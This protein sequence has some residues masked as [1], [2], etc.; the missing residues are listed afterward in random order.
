MASTTALERDLER[1][2]G[3]E[4]L[5]EDQREYLHDSTE[6]QGL[7]G[8]ADAVVAPGSV[9][10]VRELVAWCYQAGVAM[11]PRGGGTGFAGG[12]VPQGGIVV[13]FE[14]LDRV[15]SFQPEFWRVHLDSGVPTGKVHKLARESGLYFPPD[16]GASE[17]SQIGG[18]VACNAGGPH[19][20]KYGVTGDWVTGLEAVMAGGEL[21]R[22]GG[23]VRK[24]VAAY[25]LR[26]LL[27]GSEGTLGL[28]TGVWL[29]LIP[30]P[31]VQ[32]PLVAAYPGT[33]EGVA[34]LRRVYGYGLR[35][36]VL[37]YLDAGALEAS[38][39]AFPGGLD[40]R[41]RFLVLAEA[42]GS[43]AESAALAQELEEALAEAALSIR[44]VP[45]PAGQRDLWRWRGGVSYAVRNQR[46]GKMSEDIA[47]PFDRLEEALALGEEAGRAVGLPTSSWGHAGDGNLHATFMIDATDPDQIARAA[48]AAEILFEGAVELGGT[49]SG[50]HGL[51]LVKRGQLARQL[52]PAQLELQLELKR[53]FDPKNLFN[54][55]KKVVLR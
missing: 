18:N 17:Q 35:S 36:A 52:N 20:F 27:I 15:R 46:G 49:V 45:T 28:I 3:R 30:A 51:G 33:P 42:D 10:Q 22:F 4:A 19:S 50:E 53:V 1:L 13:S 40:E 43:Q 39:A 12:A 16:P 2:L 38:R 44:A 34:A 21:M 7:Q 41:A 23:A 14:R 48:R 29:K 55:G 8:R 31:E 26:S 6:M 37:E 11:V 54:P 47:V 5:I 9:E 32:L 25:D 24:D